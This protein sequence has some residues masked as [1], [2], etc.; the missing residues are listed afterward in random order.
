M[1]VFK[2]IEVDKFLIVGSSDKN[3]KVFIPTFLVKKDD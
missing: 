2:M 1:L 3:S